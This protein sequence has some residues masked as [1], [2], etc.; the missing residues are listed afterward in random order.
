MGLFFFGQGYISRG[1]EPSST[2]FWGRFII[3]GGGGGGRGGGP[4]RFIIFLEG[5]DKKRMRSIFQGGAETLEDTMPM[6][7]ILFKTFLSSTNI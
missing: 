3:K 5:L 4:D 2:K 1:G 6:F 7:N